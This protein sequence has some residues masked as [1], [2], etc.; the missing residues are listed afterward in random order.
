MSSISPLVST[1]KACGVEIFV[2]RPRISDKAVAEAPII[3]FITSQA[4][5]MLMS[6]N[7]NSSAGIGS[8]F[9]ISKS[10]ITCMSFFLSIVTLVPS[11][12]STYFIFTTIAGSKSELS[13]SLKISCSIFG[14]VIATCLSSIVDKAV[15][16]APILIF[17]TS[18]MVSSSSEVNSIKFV[19]KTLIPP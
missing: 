6:S 8:S 17:I 13:I 11:I 5:L 15:A 4:A 16:A 19:L 3:W 12:P 1:K 9:P 7:S 2:G 14:V 18:P 10:R